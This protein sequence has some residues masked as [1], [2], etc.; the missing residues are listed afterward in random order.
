MSP[1]QRKPMNAA[2]FDV[3]LRKLGFNQS[4]F[5]RCIGRTVK[6]VNR[7]ASGEQPVPTEIAM[8]LNAM[9]DKNIRP[10][11]LRP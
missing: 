11:E 4:S 7:W 5:A 9:I 6:T 8:L 1:K 10:E 3:A 2:Y